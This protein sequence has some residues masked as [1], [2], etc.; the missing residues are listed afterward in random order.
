[1][2][3]LFHGAGRVHLVDLRRPERLHRGDPVHGRQRVLLA[4]CGGLDA[5][6]RGCDPSTRRV[7]CGPADDLRGWARTPGLSD[8]GCV[9][10]TGSTSTSSSLLRVRG[11]RRANSA[12]GTGIPSNVT[13]TSFSQFDL[14]DLYP[15]FRVQR[16]AA[17][18]C[19]L[20]GGHHG[21]SRV[22]VDGARRRVHAHHWSDRHDS[23]SRRSGADR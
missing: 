17:R 21:D 4:G 9:L 2:D 19:R 7:G 12:D 14:R 5:D 1:M 15:P 11:P 16:D 23:G 10:S 8:V 20:P 22:D 18:R 6:P 3:R 13:V